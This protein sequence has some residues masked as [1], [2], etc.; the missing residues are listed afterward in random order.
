MFSCAK[1]VSIG[2]PYPIRSDY[3]LPQ[4]DASQVANDKIKAIFD[5]YESYVLYEY[6]QKDFEW[7]PASGSSA[8]FP[9]TAD[10]TDPKNVEAVVRFIDNGWLKFIPDD[11]L[12]DKWLPYRVFIADTIKQARTPGGY[13]PSQR[14]PLYYPSKVTGMSLGFADAYRIVNMTHEQAVVE[15]NKMQLIVWNYYFDKGLCD[16]SPLYDQFIELSNYASG[17]GYNAPD[18]TVYERGFAPHLMISTTTT[19]NF[20]VEVIFALVKTTWHNYMYSWQTPQT[21]VGND[22]KGFIFF[23]TQKTAA[24]LQPIF[25]QYPLFKQK[26][27]IVRNYM[28]STYGIDPQLIG[29]ANA[30][31]N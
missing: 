7:T 2:D 14:N 24:E 16:L 19:F 31:F 6:T 29:N 11:L 3:P 12:K 21:H 22:V 27:D 30:D 15:K 25:E 9:I 20:T 13:S 28:L 10:K 17:T 8:G 1:D 23:M 18:E 5:K 4:G 26:Y